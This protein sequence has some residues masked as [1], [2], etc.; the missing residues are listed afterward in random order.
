MLID[1]RKQKLS[2]KLTQKTTQ[3]TST[4]LTKKTTQ[5]TSTT[6][7]L[8]LLAQCISAINFTESWRLD[9]KGR[10]IR[11]D[12]TRNC[13][14]RQL[15]SNK[16]TWFRFSGSGGTHL[17]ES[18]LPDYSCGSQIGFWS[19]EAKPKLETGNFTKVKVYGSWTGGCKEYKIDLTVG[20]C[21]ERP[22]DYIY[23][24]NG[25]SICGGS[26]CGQL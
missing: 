19:D 7:E 24:Y 20:R 18:C 8:P 21:S 11:P 5:L 1:C 17:L 14:T 16:G 25:G 26:F 23:Q 15:S 22:D 4:K 2:T 12:G 6:T 9:H 3:I 10:K 13:D